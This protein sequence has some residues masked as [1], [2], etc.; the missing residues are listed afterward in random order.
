MIPWVGV[1]FRSKGALFTILGLPILLLHPYE[2]NPLPYF[3]LPFLLLFSHV[4]HVVEDA[5]HLPQVPILL[6]AFL[7]GKVLTY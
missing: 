5:L 2:F 6:L 1:D 3:L 7:R 4:G